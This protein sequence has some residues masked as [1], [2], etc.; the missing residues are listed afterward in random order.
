MAE[1]EL[2]D[3]EIDA[4]LEQVGSPGMTERM[5][6]GFLGDPGSLASELKGTPDTDIADG[7][8]RGVGVRA[9]KCAG[10]EEPDGVAMGQPVSRPTLI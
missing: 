7:N 1:P 5:D 4:S 6:A 10:R 2:D 9:D 3:A 8:R